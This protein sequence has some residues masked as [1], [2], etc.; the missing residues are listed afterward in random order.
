MT[1]RYCAPSG[2][3]SK[4]GLRVNGVSVFA[5]AG[6]ENELLNLIAAGMALSYNVYGWHRN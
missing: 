1:S 5:A 2:F 6:V 4:R 3:T